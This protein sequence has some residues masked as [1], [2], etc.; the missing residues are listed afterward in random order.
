MMLQLRPWLACAP[1]R[2]KATVVLV[3]ISRTSSIG[4]TP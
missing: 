1:P 4:R 2:A 3:R